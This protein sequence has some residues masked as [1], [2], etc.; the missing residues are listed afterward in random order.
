MNA[1]RVRHWLAASI[2]AVPLATTTPDSDAG[3]TNTL[4]STVSAS[5]QFTAYADDRLLPSALCV[6]AEHVKH[7]WLQRLNVA[8]NWRDPILLLVRTREESQTNA[9]PI[10]MVVFQTDK[11]LKYQI[12]CLVP[13]RID[14]ARL[15]ATIVDAL[16]S[17]WANRQ[18]PTVR[19]KAYTMAPVPVWLVQGMAA[20]IQ[21]RRE[22]LLSL[23]QRSVAAGRPPHA[24][25]LLNARSLPVDPLE[26][27]MFQA[28]AWVL[29]ESLL[30]LPD[31]RREIPGFPVG[32]RRGEGREQRILE[33]VS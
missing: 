29:T 30:G 32:T 22:A 4:V 19:N 2:V 8:D 7:E 17:E 5:R 18:Q 13:P 24:A 6:Y 15:L 28:N 16:C 10:S 14:E 33:G 11:H 25:D 20:S 26:R 3:A 12:D 31:G 27:Q 1:C 21:E 23:T 9:S